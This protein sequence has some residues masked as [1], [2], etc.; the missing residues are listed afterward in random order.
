M[1][2]SIH[3][4]NAP[5]AIGPYSQAV[6]HG[7]L[8]Y[9]SGQIPLD[10]KTGALVEGTIAQQTERVMENLSAVLTAAGSGL[11]RV[12]KTT[13]FLTAMSDFTE[14]NGAYGKY[15][16]GAKPAR[17]TVAVKELPKGARVEIDCIAA[18]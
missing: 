5:A 3:T 7:G 4:E 9:C 18:L 6:T 14:V 12:L 13:I 15:F 17:A 16:S 10:P 2:V 11:D 1:P 8:V